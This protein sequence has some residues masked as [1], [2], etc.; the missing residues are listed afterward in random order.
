MTT[1]PTALV[2][3]DHPHMMDWHNTLL[4]VPELVPVAHY[5][6]SPSKAQNLLSPPF[7]R[8]PVYGHLGELLTRHQIQAA[9]VMLPLDEA[10][11]ALLALAQAG[12]HI[13]A[14]KPVTRTAEA[15]V[16]VAS[17]LGP[18]RVF[19]AGYCWRFDPIIQQI[20][21]LVDD[22]ILG[23]LWSVEMHWITSRVGRREGEPAHRD[24]TNYLF[25]RKVSRGGML[26]WLGCHFLDIMMYVARQPV[27]TVMAMTAKQTE[28]DIDVE[29]TAACLLRFGNGMLGSLHVGYLLPSGGQTFL[30]LRGSLGWVRWDAVADRR[31]IVQSE[32]PAWVTAPTRAY[33]FPR[34]PSATYGSGTGE[35][36]LRDFVRCINEHAL[37]PAYTAADALH[38]LQVLDA[39]YAS[40]ENGQAV[41]IQP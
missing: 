30:G 31:L 4:A 29:D 33:D 15:M 3:V 11:K 18:D 14:E 36:L 9:L 27:T 21:A 25:R 28:E 35:L 19:Y 40:A 24:P 12:V 17:V 37:G 6:P 23:E 5:D 39:A 20:C 26:Q 8:L 41:S 38:V 16:R 13:M 2:G 10:E 22:G 1:I 34:P 32:H 7:D